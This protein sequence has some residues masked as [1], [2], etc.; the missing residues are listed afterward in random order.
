MAKENGYAGRIKH[1]GTQVVRPP[2]DAAGHKRGSRRL[3]GQ[4]L[5][6]GRQGG[7]NGNRSGAGHD[8]T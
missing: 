7:R 2:Y 3:S 6:N 5:R 1:S 4:D 8:Q